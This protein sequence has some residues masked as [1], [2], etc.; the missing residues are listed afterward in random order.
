MRR[1][2]FI[3]ESNKKGV[4][5]PDLIF[6][7]HFP[8]HHPLSTYIGLLFNLQSREFYAFFSR[9]PAMTSSFIIEG[10]LPISMELFF[11][12][13]TSAVFKVHMKFTQVNE[14]S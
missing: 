5:E 9:L 7:L 12:N 1:P 3:D 4:S 10:F 8:K 14:K 11:F 6:F 2:A 13:W